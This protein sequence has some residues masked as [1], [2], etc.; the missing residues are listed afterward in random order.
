MMSMGSLNKSISLFL[1]IVG[2]A[3]LLLGLI[4]VITA[5]NSV[6]KTIEHSRSLEKAFIEAKSFVDSYEGENGRLPNEE[7][8]TSWTSQFPR[9]P[10]TI[11]GI[12]IQTAPFSKDLVEQFEPIPNKAN[13]YLL[14]YWRGE[15]AE[16]YIPWTNSNTLTFDH[17]TYFFLGSGIEDGL[18]VVLI[19]GAM[20]ILALKIRPTQKP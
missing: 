12:R 20:V 15:W 1:A 18:V 11:S 19:G 2:V 5:D 4:Y 10:Y 17:S 7:E 6:S 13:T 3:I 16:Y 9:N 14:T 8:F